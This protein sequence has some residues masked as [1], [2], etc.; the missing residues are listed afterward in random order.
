MP[1]TSLM[2]L[3]GGLTM[4]GSWALVGQRLKHS[5]NPANRQVNLLRS[6]FLYTAIFCFIMFAPHLLLGINQ[7]LFPAAM[8]WCYALGHIFIYIAFIA[9]LRLT[10]SMVPRLSNKEN[11]AIAFGALFIIF[12]TI[13]NIV[14]MVFGTQPAY[15]FNNHVTLFNAAPIVG[16][17]IA[18]FGTICV[19]PAAVLILV[20][21]IRNPNARLRSF[22]LG[23]GLF[24]TMVAGP[25]HD[26]AKG[27]Q[28]YMAADI[29]AIVG[30]VIVTSGVLYHLEEHIN[31]T[32][33]AHPQQS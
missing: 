29:I 12:V 27:W 30:I 23:G 13:A 31:E 8:A 25:L 24:V 26:V 9:M 3:L 16:N 21:G 11:Y 1:L 32:A 22:L 28:L 20:N 14:T 5:S 18:A 15:D 17:S 6:Y 19:L 2:T 10:F 33:T 7:E 4:L